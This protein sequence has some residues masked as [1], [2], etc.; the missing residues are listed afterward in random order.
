M[1]RRRD[2]TDDDARRESQSLLA[3][4]TKFMTGLGGILTAVA[5]VVAAIATVLGLFLTRSGSDAGAPAAPVNALAERIS[6]AYGKFAGAVQ[7]AAHDTRSSQSAFDTSYTQWQ[8]ES[9]AIHTRIEAYVGASAASEWS[10]YAYNMMW[11]YYLFKRNGSVKHGFALQRLA[12]YLNRP[13]S[14]LDG[15]S[16]STPFKGDGSVNSTYE[17]ALR[18]LVLQL[19]M[20][21]RAIISDILHKPS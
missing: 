12:A 10:N 8:V 20:K 13:L 18:E 2:V 14:T 16:K 3:K 1:Y 5:T 6:T 4:A 21:E 15:L 17:N 7:V 19:R 9:E 11:V